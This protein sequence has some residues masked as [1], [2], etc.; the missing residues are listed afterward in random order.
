MCS[1]DL[2]AFVEN[3][4]SLLNGYNG[5]GRI[6]GRWDPT[7]FSSGGYEMLYIFDSDYDTNV[8]SY[9]TSNLFTQQSTFDIM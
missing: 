8:A 7:T 5:K 3:N 2:C 1:S 4:D 9:K 6:N